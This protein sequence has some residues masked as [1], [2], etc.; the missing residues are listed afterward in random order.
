MP[1]QNKTKIE[2]LKYVKIS[3]NEQIIIYNTFQ[4]PKLYL[5]FEIYLNVM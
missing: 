2:S 5:I 3:Q 4:L 1:C